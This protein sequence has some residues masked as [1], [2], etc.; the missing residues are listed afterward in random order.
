VQLVKLALM[1][2][3]AISPLLIRE[4]PI[5]GGHLALDFANTVDDPLGPARHDHAVTYDDLIR[6]STRVGTVTA[7]QASRLL[8]RVTSHPQDATAIM[9]EAHHLR[10]IVNEIF[11]GIADGAPDVGKHWIRLRPYVVNAVANATFED[12]GAGIQRW[13]W[14]Q[15]D[16]LAVVLHPIARAAADLL[17][18]D[19]LLR[20]KRCARCPWLFLDNSKNHSRRWCDMDICGKAQKMERYVARRAAA[21]PGATARRDASGAG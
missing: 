16:D 15:V 1:E 7:L 9:E 6:W 10:E 13:G 3:P 19:D 5:V 14:S 2:T 12:T 18:S 8:R 21:R 20:I 11:G 17:V 4:L